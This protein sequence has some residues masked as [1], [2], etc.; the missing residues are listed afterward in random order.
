MLQSFTNN[1]SIINEKPY[2]DNS[3]V[4]VHTAEYS[5]KILHHHIV[6]SKL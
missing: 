4:H 1:A 6:N 5:L 3:F 2:Y